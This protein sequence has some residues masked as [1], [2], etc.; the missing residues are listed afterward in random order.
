MIVVFGPQPMSNSF[1]A[2]NGDEL[3]VADRNR[4]CQRELRIDGDRMSVD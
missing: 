2:A 4:A 1:L 3:A